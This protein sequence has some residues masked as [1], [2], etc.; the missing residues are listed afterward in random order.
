MHDEGLDDD[1][2]SDDDATVHCPACGADVFDDAD[3]CPH[4]GHWI[5]D[6]DRRAQADASG[7]SRFV[8]VVAIVLILIFLASL[9]LAGSMF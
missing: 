1:C 7:A 5:T 2:D 9:F 4:C 6:A 8:R 3:Q